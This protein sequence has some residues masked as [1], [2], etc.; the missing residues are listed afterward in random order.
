[1]FVS[2]STY[3]CRGEPRFLSQPQRSDETKQKHCKSLIYLNF[4]GGA[5]H[6][7]GKASK[8]KTSRGSP[9]HKHW[10]TEGPGA[11]GF[12]R[13][14][15]ALARGFPGH[16]DAGL[17][18]ITKYSRRTRRV[19]TGFTQG[20]RNLHTGFTGKVRTSCVATTTTRPGARTEGPGT[21]GC[22]T[23][24]TRLAQVFAGHLNTGFT[25]D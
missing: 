22:T 1:M 24:N 13:T 8:S 2:A 15:T 12:T 11:E 19:D 14:N 23:I 5:S 25:P 20:Q 4:N 10:C 21:G 17:R 9:D 18:G 3:F 6:G 7:T 16:F